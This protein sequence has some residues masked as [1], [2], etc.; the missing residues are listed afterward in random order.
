MLKSIAKIIVNSLI[1]I[2]S[3]FVSAQIKSVDQKERVLII[4]KDG[5]GDCILF[6]PTLKAYRDHYKDAEITLIF[7][8]YFNSLMPLLGN[9]LVDKIIW[10]DHRSFSCDFKY[11]CNF[12][13]DLKRTG[14]DFALYPVYSRETIGD[15]MIKMTGA[16][17][18]IGF[19]GDPSVQGLKAKI[20][21][22]NIYTKLI[23]PPANITLELDRD[24]YFANEVS[25]TKFEPS[26][27]TINTDM[28]SS[29]H[30]DQL[31]NSNNLRN[32]KFAI[33]FPS[34]GATYKI[35]QPE[36]WAELIRYLEGRDIVPV[37]C[38]GPKDAGFINTVIQLSIGSK[39]IINLV[40][41]TDLAT[42][43]HLLRKSCFYFGSDTGILH[44][45]IA[46]G[47]PT[48]AIV[49]SGGLSRF[50]PYGNRE[51]NIAVYNKSWR[52]QLGTWENARGLK[53]DGIHPSIGSISIGDAIAGIDKILSVVI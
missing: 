32:V 23:S 16:K 37:M 45:A 2:S 49:G 41:Q 48:V 17:E 34:S 9:N 51:K 25:G 18:R 8:K 12:M 40:N 33:I 3:L 31:L 20:R 29:I 27:P 47:T 10:F 38:G 52:G 15:K 46:V 6:Y 36:K 19:N 42:L 5:L 4:R 43:A 14:Y 1:N 13:L 22:N 44:L 30:A 7:P 39:N 26:F 50:F 24:V 35:W 53:T 21:G 28:L 11:R